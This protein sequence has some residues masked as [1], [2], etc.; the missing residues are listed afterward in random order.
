M[1][2]ADF[3]DFCLRVYIVVDDLWDDLPAWVKPR[4][5]QSACSN[6]EGLTML[7]VEGWMGWDEET[8]AL[9][10]WEAHRDLVPH[11]PDRTRLDRRRRRSSDALTLIRRHPLARLDSALDRQGVIDSMPVPVK[12]FHLVPGAAS[13]ARWREQGAGYG[14]VTTK[15]QTIYSAANCTCSSRSTA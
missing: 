10:R 7:V 8:V 14:R 13:A 2:V 5:Q 6:S 4:G 12:G 15:E 9:S 3:A 11:L 1:I